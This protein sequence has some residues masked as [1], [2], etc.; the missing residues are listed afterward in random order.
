MKAL[1]VAIEN[2]GDWVMKFWKLRLGIM[3][4]G[5]GEGCLSTRQ[6]CDLCWGGNGREKVQCIS[7]DM[8]RDTHVLDQLGR[9]IRDDL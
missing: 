6:T 8:Q 9:T 7:M 5:V 4:N 1:E 3:E 2:Y